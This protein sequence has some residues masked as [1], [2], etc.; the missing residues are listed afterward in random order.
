MQKNTFFR[1]DN[2]SE[3]YN[4]L[5]MTEYF[6]SQ[7]NEDEYNLKWS[8]ISMHNSL[9]GFMVLAL[10]GTSGL[11]VIKHSKKNRGKSA[12]DILIN[13]DNQLDYFLN[14][15]DKIQKDK[16]MQQYVG[17]KTFICNDDIKRSVEWLN[18]TRNN[19]IHYLLSGY[20]IEIESCIFSLFQ[21]NKVINY[22]LNESGNFLYQYKANEIQDMNNLINRIN[23][24]TS[25]YL[26][27]IMDT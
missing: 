3:P 26:T 7:I 9:Q 21:S 2:L 14:L 15:F 17:S 8:I 24:I 19:F 20:S 22:L 1:T 27:L 13:S 18:E 25:N 23:Q 4:A 5:R 12:Y 16:Y 10:R 11:S 6:I